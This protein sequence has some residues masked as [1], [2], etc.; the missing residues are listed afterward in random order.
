MK[1]PFGKSMSSEAGGICPTEFLGK[2]MIT[3]ETPMIEIFGGSRDL[4]KSRECCPVLTRG[5]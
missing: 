1:Q 2:S 4:V 3:G 5:S